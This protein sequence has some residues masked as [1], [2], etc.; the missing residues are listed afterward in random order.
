MNK[1][2]GTFW[3]DFTEMD[4]TEKYMNHMKSEKVL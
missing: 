4:A 1:T 3:N 2:Q